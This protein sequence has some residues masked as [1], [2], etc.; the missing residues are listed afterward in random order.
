MGFLNKNYTGYPFPDKGGYKDGGD[1]PEVR[2]I[3]DCKEDVTEQRVHMLFCIS[4][5]WNMRIN[6]NMRAY[7]AFGAGERFQRS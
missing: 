6:G 7:A 2:R 4:F 5:L 3:S 1:R